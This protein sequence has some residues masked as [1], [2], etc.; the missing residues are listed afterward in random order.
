MDQE[1]VFQRAGLGLAPFRFVG[2]ETRR[3]PIP[4]PGGGFAGAPGQPMGSCDYCG[5]G[6][7]DC[8]LIES[9][10]GRRFVVG[11]ECVR[12]TGD[13]GLTAQVDKERSKR[14]KLAQEARIQR[15]RDALR[16]PEVADRLRA[17]PHGRAY[18]AERGLTRL[19]EVS[20]LMDHAGMSGKVRAARIVEQLMPTVE[21]GPAG[22]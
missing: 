12:K 14:R 6:I 10:D 21:K 4:L 15:A 5:T 2:V 8:Y 7:A 1:H 22:T 18:F 3:G 20:W 9:A 13:A 19:E 11:S 16:L 17:K